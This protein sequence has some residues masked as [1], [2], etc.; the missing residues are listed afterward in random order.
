MLASVL[1][2]KEKI[3]T[4][5][6]VEKAVVLTFRPSTL[7]IM[8]LNGMG[9]KIVYIPKSAF[10]TISKTT[11]KFVENAKMKLEVLD[12]NIQGQRMKNVWIEENKVVNEGDNE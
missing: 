9:A 4:A 3:N 11:L 8:K 12:G 5:K 1:N 7:N 6:K 10:K 2:N